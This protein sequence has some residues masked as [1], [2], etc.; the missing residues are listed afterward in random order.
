MAKVLKGE[1]GVTLFH[2]IWLKLVP[3]NLLCCP[4]S[5]VEYGVY[6]RITSRGVCV[7]V[8]DSLPNRVYG[9]S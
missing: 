9:Y 2:S 1:L 6:L 3:L 4:L 8:K 7:C 5:E